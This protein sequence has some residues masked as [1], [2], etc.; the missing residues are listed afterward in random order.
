MQSLIALCNKLIRILFSIGKKQFMFK[1]EKMLKD[2]PICNICSTTNS[3]IVN[4]IFMVKRNLINI[5][6]K[7]KHGLVGKATNVRT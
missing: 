6:L 3:S 5:N 4:R 7:V 2:I 1:E